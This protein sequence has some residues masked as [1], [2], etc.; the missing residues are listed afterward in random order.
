MWFK[1][2]RVYQATSPQAWSSTGLEQA[3]AAKPFRPCGKTEVSSAGWVAPTG[4]SLLVHTQGNNWLLKLKIEDKLLPASVVRDALAA[5]VSELEA[6]DNRR[7]GRKE[8]Q[9]L[10]E[11]IRLELLPQAFTRARYFWVWLDGTHQRVLLNTTADAPAE[12]ALNLL[13]EGLGSLPVIPF[14][15]PLDPAQQMTS[16]LEQATAPAGMQLLDTCELRDNQDDKSV[17]RCKG[18][19]LTS[20]EIQHLLAAGK[21][22][23]QL[24]L[25]WQEQISFTLTEDLKLKSLHYADYLFEEAANSNPDQDPVLALDAE[26]LLLSSSLRS[27]IN[28]LAA[29]LQGKPQQD[30][31]IQDQPT[32]SPATNSTP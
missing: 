19:D 21:R 18:Q 25:N 10:T 30:Q 26:F 31:Q 28:Q 23:T 6:K 7:V 14:S 24:G 15:T 32:S 9:T 20:T 1:S 11:E 17:V 4:G 22:V 5:K 12:L 8:R 27:L 29:L 13:R 3:A 2:L 16:W